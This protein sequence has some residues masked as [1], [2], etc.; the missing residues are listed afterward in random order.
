MPLRPGL[1]RDVERPARITRHDWRRAPVDLPAYAASGLSADTMGRGL[2]ED[3]L[4][5]GAALAGGFALGELVGQSPAEEP[6]PGGEYDG[7]R[8]GAGAGRVDAKLGM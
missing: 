3:P 7:G 5:F 6:S 2:A 1:E 8:P 4:F